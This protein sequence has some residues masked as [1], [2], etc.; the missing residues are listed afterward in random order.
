MADVSTLNVLTICERLLILVRIQIPVNIVIDKDGD[1]TLNIYQRLRPRDENEKFTDTSGKKR[2]G[3]IVAIMKV[4]RQV[5]IDN[6]SHFK[7]MLTGDSWLESTSSIV[8][9]G[10]DSFEATEVVFRVLH[11]SLNDDLYAVSISHVWE[12]IEY[13]K[14][15]F[16]DVSKLRDWFNLWADKKRILRIKKL[17]EM[18]QLLLPCYTF[19]HAKGFVSKFSISVLFRNKIGGRSTDLKCLMIGILDEETCL[20]V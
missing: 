10:V 7:A 13:C 9:L 4:N 20:R 3:T 17:D 5:L 11:N 6:S 1:L 19:D 16:I 8:D 2:H 14:S 18:A 15:T 12:V